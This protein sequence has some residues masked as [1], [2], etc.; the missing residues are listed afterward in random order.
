MW[1]IISIIL[2]VIILFLVGNNG[3]LRNENN[4]LRY[5]NVYLFTRF[6]KD[7]GEEGIRELQEEMEKVAN[8]F[9]KN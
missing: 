1:I 7:N 4:G 5:T 2:T 3:M 8:K 9:N 6:V